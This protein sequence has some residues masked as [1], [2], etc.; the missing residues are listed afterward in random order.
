[1][2]QPRQP[3]N[4]DTRSFYFPFPCL[5]ANNS[6]EAL[7]SACCLICLHPSQAH[8]C[9]YQRQPHQEVS[10]QKQLRALQDTPRPFS[11]VLLTSSTA[12]G[13]LEQLHSF[14]G[15]LSNSLEQSHVDTGIWEQQFNPVTIVHPKPISLMS[16][17]L[18]EHC[19][20]AHAPVPETMY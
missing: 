18:Q 17:S 20:P 2:I 5:D 1:M 7:Y 15:C 6:S 14:L 10:Q 12:N 8:L 19:C 11:D 4:C 13:S 9:N 3:L 16:S